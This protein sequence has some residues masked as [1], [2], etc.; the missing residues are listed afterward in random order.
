MIDRAHLRQRILD[1]ARAKGFALALASLASVALEGCAPYAAAP[2]TEPWETRPLAPGYALTADTIELAPGAE[3]AVL[4]FRASHP[5]AVVQA[6]VHF[7]IS[8]ELVRIRG[9]TVEGTAAARAE[10]V[11]FNEATL[12]TGDVVASVL[13]DTSEPVGKVLPPAT[14]Q[15]FLA[16]TFDVLPGVEEGTTIPVRFVDSEGPP[17]SNFFTTYEDGIVR[18]IEAFTTDGAIVVVVAP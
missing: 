2:P 7:A 5:E 15:P 14:E 16:V 1:L 9:L 10:S 12:E 4:Y 18:D 13:L 8:P 3:G 17:H 6:S 11:L